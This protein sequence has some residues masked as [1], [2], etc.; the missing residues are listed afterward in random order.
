M[1][2]ERWTRRDAIGMRRSK[3]LRTPR[4]ALAWAHE[5]IARV[6]RETCVVWVDSN[7]S[8]KTPAT[9]LQCGEV[10]C[11]VR[12]QLFDISDLLG[13]TVDWQDAIYQESAPPTQDAQE[14]PHG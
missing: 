13:T 5:T 6:E 9:C 11:E 1:G 4:E 12:L 8:R 3:K 7:M 14:V 10:C 2:K